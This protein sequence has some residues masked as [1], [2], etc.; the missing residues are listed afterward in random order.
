MFLIAW[1]V[2]LDRPDNLI[3]MT[4]LHLAAL[5]GSVRIAKKLLLKGVDKNVKD[6]SGKT[7]L[8]IA[9]ENDFKTLTEMFV[10]I[11]L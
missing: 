2:S 10:K 8:D 4:P 1:G 5:G 7:P 3:K 9:K 6:D 11:I